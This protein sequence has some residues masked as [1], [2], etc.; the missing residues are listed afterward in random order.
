MPLVRFGA[1]G[2][3]SSEQ[4]AHNSVRKREA[5]L[6]STRLTMFDHMKI[7]KDEVSSASINV[8]HLRKFKVTF[9][10]ILCKDEISKLSFLLLLQVYE[11]VFHIFYCCTVHF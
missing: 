2:A 5:E 7:P 8:Y 9:T 10:N 4:S 1:A 3:T 6:K 11:I